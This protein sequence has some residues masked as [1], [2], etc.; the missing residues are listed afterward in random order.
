MLESLACDNQGAVEAAVEY[1]DLLN[2]VP[3]EQRHAQLGP[4]VYASMLG[5]LSHQASYPQPFTTW[6]LCTEKDSDT[7]HSFR[8]GAEQGCC[9]FAGS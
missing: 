9:A 3:V 1:F 5:P 8:W 7:F 6:D 4:P 2:A